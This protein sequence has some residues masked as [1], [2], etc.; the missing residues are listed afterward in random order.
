MEIKAFVQESLDAGEVIAILSL[1]VQGAFD[2]AW[3]LGILIE[4]R[5]CKCPKYLYKLTMSYFTQRIATL[6][7]N[8]LR[9]KP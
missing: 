6:S 2:A 4:L 9:A 8:S 5:E 1:D 3:W 7:T